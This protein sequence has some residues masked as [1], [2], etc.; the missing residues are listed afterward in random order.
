MHFNCFRCDGIAKSKRQIDG[1]FYHPH[2]NVR[3][4]QYYCFA[5]SAVDEWMTGERGERERE[6]GISTN[7]SFRTSNIKRLGISGRAINSSACDWPIGNWKSFFLELAQMIGYNDNPITRIPI[8]HKRPK[9]DRCMNGR[10]LSV[11]FDFLTYRVRW[12]CS[13]HKRSSAKSRSMDEWRDPKRKIISKFDLSVYRYDISMRHIDFDYELYF[14]NIH[15][16]QQALHSEQ[17]NLNN[18]G[19]FV[20]SLDD[21]SPPPIASTIDDTAASPPESLPS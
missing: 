12:M 11:R 13:A 4:D 14:N 21:K 8:A 9:V 1:I 19:H 18:R 5:Y 3:F 16:K 7:V 17:S 20:L 2:L 15:D 6:R 10:D